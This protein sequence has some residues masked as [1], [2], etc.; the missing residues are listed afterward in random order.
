MKRII[1]CLLVFATLLSCC[2]L[3][4][5]S[6]GQEVS[7][8]GCLPFE[9]VKASHWFTPYIS[10][11]Y[12]NGII[13][14]MTEHTVVPNGTLTRAQFVTMLANLEGVD[15]NSYSV[16]V[17]T[18]VTKTHWYYGAIAWA[19]S[20]GIVNGMN[21]NTFAP[22]KT[23][24]RAELSSVMYSYM[25]E[26]YG[27][28]I[29]E[30]ALDNFTDKPKSEYWYYNAM[31]Y[32]VSAGLISGNNDG[33]LAATGNVTRAQAAVIFKSFMEKYFYGACEHVFSK[34]NCTSG[35]T[36]TKCSL[37]DGLPNGHILSK[38]DSVSGGKCSVC[39]IEVGHDKTVHN[40]VEATC[41]EPMTCT[42]CGAERG[43]ALG[44]N[45]VKNICTRC[46]NR[47]YSQKEGN[48]AV[49]TA[50]QIANRTVESG[51]SAE[52]YTMDITLDT[53]ANTLAGTVSVD[54]INNTDSELNEICFRYFA[55]AFEP[56]S[57]INSISNGESG[58]K[59]SF[60]KEVDN[61]FYRVA[62]ENPMKAGGIMRVDVDF[63]SCIPDKEDRFGIITLSENKRLYNLTF[64]FP[65]VAFLDDGI[66]FEEKY[67]RGG[68]ALYNEMSDYYVT[69]SAPE[70]YVILSSGRSVTEGTKTVIT[71][72][73]VREMAISACNCAEIYTKESNGITYNVLKL[74]LDYNN[75]KLLSDMY[76]IIMETAIESVDIFS[77]D[78]GDYIYDEID[79]IPVVYDDNGIGG[80]E[81][82]GI[83]QVTVPMTDHNDEDSKYKVGDF[84]SLL[85]NSVTT[86][87]HEV[88]HQWFYCA[89]GNDE[90]NEAWLDESF[91]SYLQYYYNRT[92]ERAFAMYEEMWRKYNEI[93]GECDI[94][95][96]FPH[97]YDFDKKIYYINIPADSYGKNDYIY[98]Y[99]YG[100]NFLQKLEKEMGKNAFFEM[101][102]AWYTE[103]RGGI[104]EGYAFVNH[105]TVYDSSD[106]VKEI[107][108]EYISDEYLQ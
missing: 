83:I 24:T 59:Y 82:P 108:N 90:M 17:F 45:Y 103:N 58:E 2:M 21:E 38:Y 46:R 3:T 47:P 57:K 68:E 63:T 80:M 36:C 5:S 66:W 37:I 104:V 32:A 29:N 89:I 71:A 54:L 62:L 77:R 55:P 56:E 88:A 50:K 61:T 97:G 99:A 52:K 6:D 30:S 49:E 51:L 34:A 84:F 98:V 1:S 20:E 8:G 78:V 79:I 70:E 27:V 102:S 22:N 106:A 19:Y 9:D 44:H 64:C 94:S 92:G 75:K 14:G 72:E 11:C 86:T 48:D 93:N 74:D 33:T 67:F 69:L 39:G 13:N 101:L 15:T 85:R 35:A 23:L 41:T 95:S 25:K 73:N 81:Y 105:V 53:K 26:K 10:F 28:E 91:A 18:D 12:A 4:V 31:V 43:E 107:I 60:E 96:S 7:V 100:E 87:A 40:Y 65:Q 16:S 42:R 76:E